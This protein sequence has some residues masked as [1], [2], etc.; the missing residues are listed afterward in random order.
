M[1]VNE[2]L[3]QLK[4][5]IIEGDSHQA[6]KLVDKAIELKIEVKEILDNA[7]ITGSEEVGMKYEKMEYFLPDLVIA[8]D[9]MMAAMKILKP[10]LKEQNS[11]KPKGTILVGTV[12]G[13][14][15][16][17]GKDLMVA[18]L[19]GQGYEVFDL[20]NNVPPNIFIKNAIK[21]N[22]DIIGLSGLITPSITKMQE[23]VFLLKEENIN[24]KI[25]V[26]GGILSKE[27]CNMIG[28]DDFANDGWAGI[29]KIKNLLKSINEDD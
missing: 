12:E 18:L 17:I 27:T 28:A 4:N 9:A 5:S 6:A 8:A 14:I 20:G 11:D 10:Y 16:S 1:Q 15:H 13:D 29:R 24:S 23:I 2:V 25:I 26:G 7:I 21:I 19:E 22:P 3:T